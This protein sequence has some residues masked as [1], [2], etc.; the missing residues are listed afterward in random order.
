MTCENPTKEP[1]STTDSATRRMFCDANV[2]RCFLRRDSITHPEDA[3]ESQDGGAGSVNNVN[4]RYVDGERPRPIDEQHR[5]PNLVQVVVRLEAL[6]EG[7]T[8]ADQEEA[9]LREKPGVSSLAIIMFD[10]G[11]TGA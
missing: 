7:E 10:S 4:A 5:H 11:R 2:K 3:G 1:S 8:G 9:D 6:D